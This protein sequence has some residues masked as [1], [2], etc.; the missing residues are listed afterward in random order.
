MTPIREAVKKRGYYQEINGGPNQQRVFNRSM[1]M[2]PTQVYVID[3]AD[4]TTDSSRVLKI[5]I[6]VAIL[7]ILT[8]VI[9]I[10]ARSI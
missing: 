6:T 8:L 7:I 3:E 10:L 5:A 4:S 1:A 9:L 2:Q